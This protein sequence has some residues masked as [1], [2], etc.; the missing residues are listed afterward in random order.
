MSSFALAL[1]IFIITFAAGTAG[2]VWAGVTAAPGDLSIHWV[3]R[4][5]LCA[6]IVG[7]VV[8]CIVLGTQTFTHG[9]VWI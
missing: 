9:F 2:F 1:L 7:A 3:E 4:V 8:S 6:M 5:G